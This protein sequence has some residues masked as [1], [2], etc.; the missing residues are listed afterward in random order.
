MVAVIQN[1]V[2][3]R[4]P[5]SEA[6]EAGLELGVRTDPPS[7]APQPEL[8]WPAPLGRLWAL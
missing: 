2:R 1:K 3:P 8:F 4:G 5:E 7:R 6:R